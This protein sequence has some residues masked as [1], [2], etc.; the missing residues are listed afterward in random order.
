MSDRHDEDRDLAA[1]EAR[2]RDAIG[3]RVANVPDSR[4]DGGL[5][6]IKGVVGTASARDRR[7]RRALTIVGIAAA[8]VIVAGS[9]ALLR[10]DKDQKVSTASDTPTTV[11]PTTVPGST[12]VTTA[13]TTPED[14]TVWPLASAASRSFDS[15][16]AA[17]FSFA[18][19]YLHMSDQVQ[20]GTA[21]PGADSSATVEIHPFAT[22]GP[23]TTVALDQTA[24]GWV[25]VSATAPDVQVETPKVGDPASDPLTVSGQSTA[26]EAVINLELRPQDTGERV[27]EVTATMGGAN[28][29]LGP[30]STTLHPPQDKGP[31]VLLVYEADAS[32]QGEIS[33]ATVIRLRAPGADTGSAAPGPAPT[34]YVAL[35]KSGDLTLLDFEGHVQRPLGSYEGADTLDYEPASGL[36]A[37]RVPAGECGSIVF[38]IVSPPGT[39]ASSRTTIDPA[40]TP[41]FSPDGTKLAYTECGNGIHVR[42]LATD[43]DHVLTGTE[44]RLFLSLTWAGNG[45]VAAV[46]SKQGFALFD[47]STGA[48]TTPSVKAGVIAGRGRFGSIAFVDGDT[49][50]SLNVTNGDTVPLVAPARAPVTLDADASGA[51]LIWVDATGDVWTWSGGEPN[52]VASGMAAA[53]W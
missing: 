2:L 24:R 46:E 17:T 42:D 16:E 11:A 43:D 37:V 22:G 26:F 8:I 52:Q 31:L 39:I 41:A 33:A 3:A 12:T 19:E 27:G 14:T 10:D 38:A 48:E 6:S 23:A 53:A 30:F 28:G 4:G 7:R 44:G 5:G 40:S 20:V 34:T 51:N 45:T 35:S 21:V 29:E 36:V 15:P 47:A 50:K 18:T 9:F 49:I 1:M 32:G 13:P 25:V